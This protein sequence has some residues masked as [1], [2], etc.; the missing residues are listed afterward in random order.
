GDVARQDRDV[1]DPVLADAVEPLVEEEGLLPGDVTDEDVVAA[2][3]LLSDHGAGELEHAHPDFDRLD[4]ARRAVPLEEVEASV[5]AQT[6]EPSCRMSVQ[7]ERRRE[8]D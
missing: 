4:P 6:D 5:L 8:R 3:V 7:R 2:A 1:A